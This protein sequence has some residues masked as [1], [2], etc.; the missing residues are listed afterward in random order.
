M[1]PTFRLL[2]VSNLFVRNF[3]ISL[4]MYPGS[5]T[6]TVKT[7]RGRRGHSATEVALCGDR[8]GA[9]RRLITSRLSAAGARSGQRDAAPLPD[10]RKVGGRSREVYPSCRGGQVC[11]LPGFVDSCSGRDGSGTHIMVTDRTGGDGSDSRVDEAPLRFGLDSFVC[12]WEVGMTV[13]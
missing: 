5:V 7:P 6:V 4:L 11:K 1:S 9:L 3:G 10:R 13:F 8:S 12:H 2:H